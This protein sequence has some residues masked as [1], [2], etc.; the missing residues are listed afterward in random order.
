[1]S[2]IGL[3]LVLIGGVILTVGDI[4]RKV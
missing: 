1:M 3:I 2:Y 4:F